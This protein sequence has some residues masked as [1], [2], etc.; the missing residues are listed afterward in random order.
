MFKNNWW[1]IGDVGHWLVSATTVLL[2]FW[3]GLRVRKPR[4]KI[5][6]TEST[7][8]TPTV[9]SSIDVMIHN[10]GSEA[11]YIRSIKMSVFGLNSTARFV[12]LSNLREVANNLVR[13]NGAEDFIAPTRDV[14]T[15]WSNL[16][17]WKKSVAA[18]VRYLPITVTVQDAG[19]N[20]YKGVLHYPWRGGN[21]SAV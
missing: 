8:H 16:P 10:S 15:T 3:L 11:A 18:A 19:G 4:L 2:A 12:D 13:A 20:A 1:W 5:T 17:N 7:D 14:I 6:V 21:G 9:G